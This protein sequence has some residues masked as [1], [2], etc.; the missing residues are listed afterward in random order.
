MKVV[1]FFVVIGLALITGVWEAAVVRW[2][3]N[4]YVP[5]FWPIIPPVGLAE[6]WVIMVIGGMMTHQTGDDGAQEEGFSER[7][8]GLAA[9]SLV[10]ASALLFVL[11]VMWIAWHFIMVKP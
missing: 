6:M 7:M 10:K 2:I 4:W 11:F 3:W 5:A 8:I 9:R 1:A